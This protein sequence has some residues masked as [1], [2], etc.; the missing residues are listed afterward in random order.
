MLQKT[1]RT[2]SLLFGALLGGV[3]LGL[4]LAAIQ[5]SS[6][7]LPQTMTDLS[8]ALLLYN[9][10]NPRNTDVNFKKVAEYYGLRWAVVDVAS[11]SLT[12]D[13]LRDEDGQYYPAIGIDAAT[14]SDHLDPGGLAVLETAIDQHGVNLLVT[15]AHSDDDPANLNELTDGEIVSATY[16]TD[17]SRDYQLSADHPE[18]LRELSGI[19]I[20]APYDQY[21]RA[22]TLASGATHVDVLVEATDA[23]SQTYPVFVRFQDGAGSIFVDGGA[24]FHNLEERQFYTLYEAWPQDG[25]F[26]F[27]QAHFMEV[28]P[29]M[30]FVRYTAGDEA[31]HNDHDYANLVIDDPCLQE[32]FVNLNYSELLTHLEAHDYHTTIATV[33]GNCYDQAEQGVI[34]LFLAHPDRYSL[35]VHGNNHDPCPEFTDSTLL[36]EQRADL[37]QALQR[38][39]IHE[40]L[41]GVPY[42]RVMVFPCKLA[43]ESTLPLLKKLN[44]VA[45]LNTQNTPLSGTTST[46]WDFE[47]YPAIMDYGNYAL[48][49]RHWQSTSPYPFNLF[50][51][52]PI[53]IY[54]HE[55]DFAPPADIG[56]Y[57]DIADAIHGLEGEVEWRSLDH[58]IKRLYLERRND[59]GSVTVQ[60][61]T[62]HLILENETGGSLLYHLQKEEDRAV[63][64]QSVTVDGASHAYTLADGLLELDVTIKAAS[65]AEIIVTY[66]DEYSIFLPLVGKAPN[67]LWSEDFETITQPPRPNCDGAASHYETQSDLFMPISKPDPGF[68]CL[69]DDCPYFGYV[70]AGNHHDCSDYAQIA[71]RNDPLLAQN[72]N[73][74]LELNVNMPGNPGRDYDRRIEMRKGGWK[75]GGAGTWNIGGNEIW[76]SAWFYIPADVDIDPWIE[77]TDIVERREG[78]WYEKYN[79]ILIYGSGYLH[80][81]QQFNG[82]T[83]NGKT[84]TKKVPVGRWVH[85]EE[86]FVRSASN[87]GLVEVFLDGE[88][89]LANYNIR[90]MSDPNAADRGTQIS[91][92]LYTDQSTAHKTLYWDNI[93]ISR[94]R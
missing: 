82:S 26:E 28:V 63:P 77:L 34:D 23:Y 67:V 75:T 24:H 85:L 36:E 84:S 46:A 21:D 31:W 39:D 52:K 80:I 32:P 10:A 62:N 29:L 17:T 6:A 7:P 76:R 72:G 12:N 4:A 38:M 53:F 27:E 22:L 79:Q 59:D 5:A 91:F 18:I 16:P 43:G 11:T 69:P 9:A 83:I 57:D 42:G 92:K 74:Y 93:V 73:Q 86:H 25:Y 3:C 65:T 50:R 60:W 64:I 33:P 15:R 30:A 87:N 40:T 14:L 13:L 47:M 44:Y 89:W 20:T 66:D 90:T 35:G 45:T 48:V 37:E 19:T 61:Y 49:T 88:L 71:L 70:E 81:G 78:G 55:W 54:G 2:K 58:I 68:E 56:A 94:T 8:D 51:D 41:T 1:S